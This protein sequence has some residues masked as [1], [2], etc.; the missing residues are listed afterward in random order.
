[1]WKIR[2]KT[3]DIFQF[4]HRGKLGTPKFS[5][6]SQRCQVFVTN[7]IVKF[8][9]RLL[10]PKVKAKFAEE[11]EDLNQLNYYEKFEYI[12]RIRAIVCNEKC[13]CCGRICGLENC[14]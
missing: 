12:E 14:H 13:P 4:R 11:I 7:N 8:T 6:R 10:D 3:T 1:M 5:H 2:G 9:K